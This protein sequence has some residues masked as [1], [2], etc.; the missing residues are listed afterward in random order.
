VPGAGKKEA[1]KTAL[2]Y[3]VCQKRIATKFLTHNVAGQEDG[4]HAA[5]SGTLVASLQGMQNLTFYING[6]APPFSTPKPVRFICVER[7]DGH[8]NVP[9]AELTWGQCH[10]YPNWTGPIKVPSV[11][12]V[13]C[14]AVYILWCSTVNMKQSHSVFLFP[15]LSFLLFAR[16]RTS[17]RNLLAASRMLET[18]SITKNFRASAISCSFI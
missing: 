17:L 5:P 14:N 12:Q 8:M 4:S 13:C 6:R 7:D 3:I 1:P 18:Q 16:W 11:C 2:S 10:A 9:I 15:I